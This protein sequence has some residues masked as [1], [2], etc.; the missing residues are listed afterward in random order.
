MSVAS[1]SK[2]PRYC[3]VSASME[4]HSIS[5]YSDCKEAIAA[6]RIYKVGRN[7][8]GI[9]VLLNNSLVVDILSCTRALH[10]SDNRVI[11]CLHG[12]YWNY[13]FGLYNSQ[14]LWLNRIVPICG[15]YFTFSSIVSAY[16]WQYVYQLYYS[17]KPV[18]ITNGRIFMLWNLEM[19]LFHLSLLQRRGQL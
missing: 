5:T 11:G 19:L 4:H 2:K 1:I 16:R 10:I 14:L 12:T 17:T 18:N 15:Y 7:L 9:G 6:S 8:R 3:A 13:I